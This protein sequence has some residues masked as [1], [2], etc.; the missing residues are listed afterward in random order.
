MKTHGVKT[1]FVGAD[2]FAAVDAAVEKSL[3]A[4]IVRIESA[5]VEQFPSKDETGDSLVRRGT[6]RDTGVRARYR[7][8]LPGN[9]PNVRL[10]GL[11]DSIT[12]RKGKMRRTVGTDLVYARIHEFGGTINH[13]GGTPYIVVGPGRAR[14][15]SNKK[16]AELESQGKTIKRTRRHT[17]TMPARPYMRPGFEAG[18]DPAIRAMT[19]M[20]EKEMAKVEGV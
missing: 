1:E 10:G 14:F 20:L 11:R 8:S 16:A 3:Q 6:G 19:R 4:G 12:V 18:R 15:I 9:P 2:F 7:A 13:P 17:I 5:V